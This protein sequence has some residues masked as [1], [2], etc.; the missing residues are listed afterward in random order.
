MPSFSTV[1]GSSAPVTITLTGL[2][3]SEAGVA[4]RSA[5]ISNSDGFQDFE[6]QVTITGASAIA[7]NSAA[8]VYLYSSA[9]SGTTWETGGNTDALITLSGAEKCLGSV[10]MKAGASVSKVFTVAIRGGFV[11]RD[12]GICVSQNSGVALP[13]G[14]AIS[15]RGVRTQ[16]T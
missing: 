4:R 8:F 7:E 9:D 11:P 5:S 15:I 14:C 16:S 12:F 10:P 2:A 13:S 6:L 1:Y 3:S